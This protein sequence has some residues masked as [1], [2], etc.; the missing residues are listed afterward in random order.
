MPA[1]IRRR[2]MLLI[3]TSIVLIW[4]IALISSYL[5]AKREVSEWEEARLAEIAQILALLDQRNLTTLAT[6]RIDLREEEQ[7]GEAGA[8]D[9]DDDDALPRDA[10]FQVRGANGEVLAGSPR[11]RALQ[12]WDLP[13]P[14][15]SGAQNMTLGGEAW[16]RRKSKMK[17]RIREI[18]GDL[19]A[20][21]AL[22]GS[23]DVLLG[24]LHLVERFLH[25][26]VDDRGAV[27]L[28]RGRRGGS[29][30]GRAAG[31]AHDRPLDQAEGGLRSG[32]HP[33]FRGHV[34]GAAFVPQH[35]LVR[36]A[37]A[38]GGRDD[39]DHL[40]LQP[41]PDHGEVGRAIGLARHDDVAAGVDGL[42][43]LEMRHL[44]IS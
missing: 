39:V 32:G 16:Q 9:S 5:Q 44:M 2:L 33:P 41:V 29:P 38:G 19:I 34:A 27:D 3:L 8:N 1:S 12:A 22:R 36:I 20:T 35:V 25:G 17:E 7:G 18:A 37:A 11:L 42:G 6:A 28:R 21:A 24:T 13:V 23:T 14:P 4:G 30:T 26:C 15:A 43:G 31:P 10:L 40:F